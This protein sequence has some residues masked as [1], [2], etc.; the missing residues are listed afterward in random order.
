MDHDDRNQS[1]RT[2]MCVSCPTSWGFACGGGM[3]GLSCHG[4]TRRRKGICTSRRPPWSCCLW[5][6]LS[7]HG[8]KNFQGWHFAGLLMLTFKLG[9]TCDVSDSHKISQTHPTHP[10]PTDFGGFLSGWPL[11]QPV[12]SQNR[13]KFWGGQPRGSTAPG[14]TPAENGFCVTD[15]FIH[16]AKCL[17]AIS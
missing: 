16:I 8:E 3:G 2:V 17:A 14:D 5:L 9:S 11:L 4:C 7:A 10:I 13:P 1:R 15:F 12:R 6:F